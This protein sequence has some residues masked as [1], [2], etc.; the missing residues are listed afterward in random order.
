MDETDTRNSDTH[1][2][3]AEARPKVDALDAIELT[4]S[5]DHI[6]GLTKARKPILA[7]EELLW[8]SLD[9]DA[10]NVSVELAYNGLNGLDR[11]IVRDDGDGID[12]TTRDQSF[13]LLGGSPKR[14]RAKT[15]RERTIHGKEGKGRFR[16]FALGSLVEWVSRY[17]DGPVI[18]EW[19]IRGDLSNLKRFP[20]TSPQPAGKVGEVSTGTTV[21]VSNVGVS[22]GT[23]TSDSARNDLLL[24]FAPYLRSYPTVRIDIDGRSLE[25]SSVVE[26]ETEQDLTTEVN[27]SRI[28]AKL[29]VIEWKFSVDRRILLCNADGFPR[30]EEAAAIHAKGFDFTAYVLSDA[31]GKMS[32][33]ELSLGEM[34]PRIRALADAA[35]LRMREHFKAREKDRWRALLEQWKA[36]G[37]Y[38]YEGNATTKVAQAERDVFDILALSVH[39]RLPGFDESTREGKAFTFRLLRQALQTNPSSLRLILTEVLKLPKQEQDDFAELL[40]RAKLSGIVRAAKVVA[41]RAKFIAGLKDLLF[42]PTTKKA[43]KERSQLQ[44]M[45]VREL[46]IFGDKYLLGSDDQGLRALLSAHMN[47][48]GRDA[49]ALDEV[50]DINGADAIP[51]LMLYRRYADRQQGRFE[52]LVVELKR[53]SVKGGADEIQQIKNYAYT[54]LKD[55]RF[56]KG[57]TRW[58]FILV[59]N[60]LNAAG[61]EE[62]TP[63]QGRQ[64][65]HLVE[66]DNLNIFVRLWATILQESEWRHE[67]YRSALELELQGNDGREFV[68]AK[69]QRFLPAVN[70][71]VAKS[72]E[73]R[74]ARKKAS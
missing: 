15:R 54:V 25:A 1:P 48:L 65:G 28:E 39:Q 12:P 29:R 13:G 20:N 6:A 64:F 45:L 53:P 68:E 30:Y 4:L 51:D 14:F 67:F 71:E 37:S 50:K 66:R 18:R 69:H 2:T 73:R 49:I 23:L 27:G 74:P 8:N 21:T 22:P 24:H 16:A 55:P 46:W 26:C 56:D 63:Q 60:D 36:E 62:C 38:P 7:V 9:A 52:H 59:V 43:L 19:A 72:K 5:D 32:E 41:D 34:E 47:I 11:I 35:R 17:A 33:S 61:M 58:T 70:R 40:Q 3:E 10:E 31:I 42:D 57:A 44:R